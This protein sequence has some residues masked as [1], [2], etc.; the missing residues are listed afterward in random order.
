MAESDEPRLC[1]DCPR[2]KYLSR[3]RQQSYNN[4]PAA[5]SM[6]KLCAKL[7]A[8]DVSAPRCPHFPV[9]ENITRYFDGRKKKRKKSP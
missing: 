5:D 1:R 3:V 2:R 7:R 4:A 9:S 6:V 8:L